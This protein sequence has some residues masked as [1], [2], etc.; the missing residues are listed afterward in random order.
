MLF[1][2]IF[3]ILILLGACYAIW[4]FLIEPRLPDNEDQEQPEHL[5][6]LNKKLEELEKLR[7]EYE[8][9]KTEREVTEQLKDLDTQIDLLIKE[10]RKIEK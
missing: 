2:A 8:N 4:K 5:K 3:T 10:I 9:V 7:D 6:I 1:Q